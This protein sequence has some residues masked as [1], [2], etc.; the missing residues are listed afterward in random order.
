MGALAAATYT[1]ATAKGKGVP[2]SPTKVLVVDAPGGSEGSALATLERNGFI[3]SEELLEEQWLARATD[4]GVDED[5]FVS[6]M[7]EL[8]D[9]QGFGYVAFD[10]PHLRD[11][12]Q[13]EDLE[14]VPTQE[15]LAAAS[16]AVISAGELAHPHTITLGPPRSD[17]VRVE[18]I[19]LLEAL[20]DQDRFDPQRKVLTHR[21]SVDELK[22][23][24][25]VK[26]A[27]NLV[28]ARARIEREAREM[29][30]AQEEASYAG[31][32]LPLLGEG[33]AGGAIPLADGSVLKVA[34]EV[35]VHSSNGRRIDLAL[36][37]VIALERTLE[38]HE[39]IQPL[40]ELPETM[41][42]FDTPEYLPSPSGSHVVIKTAHGS[43]LYRLDDAGF[44]S[45][46]EVAL[47]DRTTEAKFGE[48]TDAG[49][50]L[51]PF[52]IDGAGGIRG[53]WPDGTRAP[54]GPVGGVALA[55]PRLVWT[56]EGDELVV[57]AVGLRVPEDG[58][59]TQ[60]L[61]LLGPSG[62]GAVYELPSEVLGGMPIVELAKFAP[63]TGT[64]GAT[65]YAVVGKKARTVV[66]IEL[67][68]EIIE[69]VSTLAPPDGE[70]WTSGVVALTAEEVAVATIAGSDGI[71]ELSIS[72]DGQHAVASTPDH[73]VV[74]LPLLEP[75]DLV[76]V[77]VDSRSGLPLFTAD[78]S[79]LIF[80]SRVTMG[81]LR[82]EVIVP[83]IV[84]L[85][86]LVPEQV[87]D[88][89]S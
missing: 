9:T 24:E 27:R 45:L 85:D 26:P 8:A 82:R 33:Q 32:G 69:R 57:A 44:V 64:D 39:Q 18:G 61:F 40:G 31:L 83:R 70:G 47:P 4:E 17:V 34:R 54:L 53:Y 12:S 84:Y 29:A 41:E 77:P 23:E 66:R 7:L 36:S 25:D 74:L 55:S 86:D 28:E 30:L 80:E 43:T 5:D 42:V 59:P 71:R 56:G 21:P 72:P 3:G 76:S 35:D 11:Y 1:F 67:G 10:Q 14:G 58:E 62:S 13:V 49:I 87:E 48:V 16:Y 63:A 75:G 51:R 81:L 19:G 38:D 20:L 65:I 52:V 60:S 37:D 22:L 46:G 89:E 68:P 73:R 6:A 50:V 15:E 88:S 79:A 78:A 2:E